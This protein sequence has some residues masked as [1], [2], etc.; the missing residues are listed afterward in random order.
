LKV[1]I[2]E[3]GTIGVVGDNSTHIG[4]SQKYV[5]GLFFVKKLP[6]GC[7]VHQIELSVGFPD[8]IGI[9]F[10]LQVFPNSRSNQSA[11]SG[12]IYFVF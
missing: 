5:I 2:N 11:M 12:H 8:Q 7:T 1:S 10:F 4:R 9:S 3:I 6:N